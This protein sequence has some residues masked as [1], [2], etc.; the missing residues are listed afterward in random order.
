MS[1]YYKVKPL[2][3][4]LRNILMAIFILS[5]IQLSA[6]LQEKTQENIQE[7]TQTLETKTGYASFYGKAFEG[8]E[9]ASGEIFDKEE[10]VAA[11]PTYPLGTIAKVTNLENQKSVT[12]RIIDRGPTS[13]NRKEGVIIDLS[14]Q[15]AKALDFIVDGRT[16]VK[17]EVLKWGNNERN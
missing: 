12:I 6:C 11:H 5:Q 8:K 13:E 10:Y 7:K 16:Q 4:I 15:S 2:S 1:N 17:V 14:K 9:T 3:D